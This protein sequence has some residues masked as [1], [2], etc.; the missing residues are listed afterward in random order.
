MLYENN[1]RNN[2]TDIKKTEWTKHNRSVVTN[3]LSKKNE[4]K[5]K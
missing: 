2:K 3:F 1:I 5:I 4:K